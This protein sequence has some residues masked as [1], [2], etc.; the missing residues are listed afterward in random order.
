MEMVWG[1]IVSVI[2]PLSIQ[3]FLLMTLALLVVVLMLVVL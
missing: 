2:T 3:C 1:D